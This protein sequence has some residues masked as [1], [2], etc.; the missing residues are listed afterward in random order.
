VDFRGNRKR[1]DLL[2]KLAKSYP[3][4]C[5]IDELL[6]AVWEDADPAYEPRNRNTVHT[7]VH[8]LKKALGPLGIAVTNTR[9]WGYQLKDGRKR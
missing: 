6:A 4:P 2:M 1:W 5:P 3:G 7:T 9:H 8:A